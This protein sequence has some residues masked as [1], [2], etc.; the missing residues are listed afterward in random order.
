MA[1]SHNF[2]AKK[3]NLPA[4]A[5]VGAL[6]VA[7]AAG[8]IIGLGVTFIP[9]EDEPP[10]PT[11]RFP[12]APPSPEPQTARK[13][14]R[15]PEHGSIITT[16][17]TPIQL[18]DEGSSQVDINDF[19]EI[20]DIIDKLGGKQGGGDEDL[21]KLLE[22]DRKAFFT[23]KTAMPKNDTASWVT[24]DDYPARAIRMEAEGTVSVALTIGTDGR[25]S[26]CAVTSSSGFADLDRVTCN[27][28][29]A[30]A[31]FEAAR[32]NTGA[33]VL[34]SYNKSVRWELPPER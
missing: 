27:K 16:P 10:L 1:Y 5:A 29:S 32:D 7:I 8:L 11:I 15:E 25:V 20:D 26:N 2:E 18:T 22:R 13:R 9:Q 12:T 4:I 31:R 21:G 17:R 19:P 34:G 30:R 6:H 28:I 33:N 23:P 14:E 3:P 24:T